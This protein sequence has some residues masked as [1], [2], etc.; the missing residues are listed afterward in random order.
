MKILITSDWHLDAVTAGVSRFADLSQAVDW[1]VQ[2][3]TEHKVALYTFLGDLCDPDANRAP[4]CVAKAINTA[5]VLMARGIASRWLVGNHDVI[6]DGSGTSTMEPIEAAG[7][8]LRKAPMHEL[9]TFTVGKTLLVWLPYVPKVAAYDPVEFIRSCPTDV[10]RVLVFGHLNVPGIIPASETHDMPRGR[11]VWMPTET[12]REHWNGK[13]VLLNG[14]YHS[15]TSGKKVG[16]VIPGTLQRLTFGEQDNVVGCFIVDLEANTV[17]QVVYEQAREV[18]T[19]GPTDMLWTVKKLPRTKFSKTAIVRLQPP[20][21][22]PSSRIDELRDFLREKV[23]AVKVI[24]APKSAASV[25]TAEKVA[26][27]PRMNTRSVIEQLMDAPMVADR[28][29]VRAI[30]EQAMNEAGL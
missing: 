27:A 20:A 1:T 19:Y 28:D 25:A 13:A 23:A 5:Q 21:D 14:H 6:E 15:S 17:E 18:V 12:I 26:P 7:H 24:P 16:V 10:D 9:F 8:A 4:A 2:V 22:C 29:A 3:A 11:E 30:V